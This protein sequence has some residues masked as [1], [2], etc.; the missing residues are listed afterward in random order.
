MPDHPSA[1]LEGTTV[2]PWSCRM[3]HTSSLQNKCHHGVDVPEVADNALEVLVVDGDVVH[4]HG[5]DVEAP[6]CQEAATIT[7]LHD[8]QNT[9][10]QTFT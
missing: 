7:H 1:N 10:V 6:H 4:I 8:T 2:I 9:S 5:R 3:Q